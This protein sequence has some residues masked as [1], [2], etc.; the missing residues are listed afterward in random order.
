MCWL[1]QCLMCN[2]CRYWD[3]FSHLVIYQLILTLFHDRTL[4][5]IKNDWGV[6]S[7]VK[8]NTEWDK[9][10]LCNH[11]YLRFAMSEYT[12]L[13]NAERS[14]LHENRLCGLSLRHIAQLMGRSSSTLSRE[15]RRN[16]LPSGHYQ[17]VYADGCYLS[18]R[19]RLALLEKNDKLR[20]YVIDRLSWQRFCG[21]GLVM[22]YQTRTRC[23]I[24]MRR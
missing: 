14:V 24:S 3:L 22:L 9:V 6:S 21:L 15:L 18:R 23:G 12:H 1:S 2:Y 4:L 20:R 13:T 5:E 11:T 10:S 17:P 8:S 19:N 16:R 7:R